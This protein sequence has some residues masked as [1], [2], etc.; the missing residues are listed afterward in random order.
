MGTSILGAVDACPDV[1]HRQHQ[2]DNLLDLMK[3]SG[4]HANDV[5]RDSLTLRPKRDGPKT[6]PYVQARRRPHIASGT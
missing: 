4:S 2:M 3:W 1:R 5:E 6:V